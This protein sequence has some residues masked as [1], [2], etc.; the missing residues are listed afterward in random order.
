MT[1]IGG[2]AE[3]S[4]SRGLEAAHQGAKGMN[5]NGKEP[6]KQFTN[7]QNL[8][9]AMTHMASG[10]SWSAVVLDEGG[11]Y[12]VSYEI[13]TAGRK[14]I[15]LIRSHRRYRAFTPYESSVA[16]VKDT[17][18]LTVSS[19]EWEKSL[20]LEDG[21]V[22]IR[23]QHRSYGRSREWTLPDHGTIT[24][25]RMMQGEMRDRRTVINVPSVVDMRTAYEQLYDGMDIRINI[26]NGGR[27]TVRVCRTLDV[28]CNAVCT[29]SRRETLM[30]MHGR[31]ERKGE[32]TSYGTHM[33]V[34][35]EG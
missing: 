22:Q 1:A 30:S 24:N 16:T 19:V 27:E 6:H 11:K 5:T 17:S 31:V 3:N 14:L 33:R 2:G 28:K 20:W 15:E 18:S 12:V 8:R 34:E 32:I 9:S 23:N 13:V 25:V 4:S 21:V 35:Y 7:R 26:L 10:E 29:D